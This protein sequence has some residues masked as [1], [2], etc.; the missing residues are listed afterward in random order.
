MRLV[1]HPEDAEAE[2]LSSEEIDELVAE[3]LGVPVMPPKKL[4]GTLAQRHETYAG[5]VADIR[6]ALAP[7]RMAVADLELLC[8]EKGYPPSMVKRARK[9][10]GVKAWKGRGY[11]ANG[12]WFVEL[13]TRK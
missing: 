6:A 12:R 1:D 10:L 5:C 7:G 13:P 11:G 3:A 8:F 4:R 9:Q 2:A